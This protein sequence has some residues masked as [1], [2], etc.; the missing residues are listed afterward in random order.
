MIMSILIVILFIFVTSFLGAYMEENKVL[1]TPKQWT[2]FGIIIGV[3]LYASYLD[4]TIHLQG[5]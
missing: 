3:I 1:K 5:L 2:G 4:I